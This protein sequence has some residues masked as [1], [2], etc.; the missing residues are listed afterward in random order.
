MK[1]TL[2][3]F[4]AAIVLALVLTIFFGKSAF[5][6]VRVVTTTTDLA[7]IAKEVGGD[8]IDVESLGHGN[9]DPHFVDPKPS[10]MVK[11]QKANLLVVVGL[12]LE[13]G[14]IPPLIDGSRNPRIVKGAAGYVDASIG[15]EILDIP[16]V[17]IE[18]SMGD[19]HIFGNP[20]YWLDPVNGKFIARNIAQGLGRVDPANASFYMTNAKRFAAKLDAKLNEWKKKLAPYKGY[21]IITYHAGWP[22]FARRFGFTI[23]EHVESKPGIPPSPTHTMAVINTIKEKR[24]KVI[25]VEP[26][27]DR[28]APDAIAAKT[29]AKVLVLPTSVGGAEG[30]DTY[31]GLFDYNIDQLAAALGK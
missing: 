5:A 28:K 30:V 23:A 3:S 10:F 29:G 13:I 22:N 17:R 24:I 21:E 25:I 12:D 18:R 31:I 11:L 4:G 27:H 16:K 20:H 9:Q 14:Y 7:S 26:F 6:K 1:R 15:C 2:I 19:I 8:K